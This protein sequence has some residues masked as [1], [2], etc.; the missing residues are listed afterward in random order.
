MALSCVV[1]QVAGF[2]ALVT[3]AGCLCAVCE[4]NSYNMPPDHVER[5]AGDTSVSEKHLL[6]LGTLSLRG[7]VQHG[8]G[9]VMSKLVTHK[10]PSKGCRWG[11]T[12]WA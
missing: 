4:L 3:S 10:N 1:W 9:Q 7:T 11:C 12:G 2:W 8:I 6:G 5:N